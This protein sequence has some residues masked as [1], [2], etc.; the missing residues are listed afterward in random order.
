MLFTPEPIAS[1][2]AVRVT[3]TL[4][5]CQ[6]AAFAAGA[7]DELIVGFTVSVIVKSAFETSKK[8]L[9]TAST[10]I[11]ASVVA[12]FGIVTGSEPSFAVLAAKTTGYVWPPSDDRLIFTFAVP[13]GA[14]SVPALSQVTVCAE[15]PG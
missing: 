9:P 2:S 7:T 10:L 5:L 14:R 13:M 15:P 3:V 1:S 11:R 6:P 12:M 4:L 8:M